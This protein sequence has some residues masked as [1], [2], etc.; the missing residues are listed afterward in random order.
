[1]RVCISQSLRGDMMREY[2]GKP[3]AGHLGR[4]KTYFKIRDGQRLGLLQLH[5]L[6]SAAKEV[7]AK[8][9][10]KFEGPY[11]LLKVQHINFIVWKAGKR[12]TVNKDEFRLYPQRKSDENVIRGKIRKAVVQD[13]K[14]VVLKV[15]DVNQ[16]GHKIVRMMGQVNDE[17]ITRKKYEMC[18]TLDDRRLKD[19]NCYENSEAPHVIMDVQFLKGLLKNLLCDVCKSYSLKIDIGEKLRLS[20]EISVFCTFCALIKSSNFTSRRISDSEGKSLNVVR[21]QVKRAYQS[22]SVIT[23]I[24]FTFDDTWF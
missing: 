12:L 4:I 16:I 6:S 1:M 15:C 20:R 7:V 11:R 18:Q 3:T 9:K 24:D 14:Q 10:P 21:S 13:I 23:D 5:P 8:F 22:S 17:S 2:D 19:L